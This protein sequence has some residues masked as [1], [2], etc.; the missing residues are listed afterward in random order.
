MNAIRTIENIPS[1]TNLRGF[2]DL[3]KFGESAKPYRRYGKS[4]ISFATPGK[5]GELNKTI[6]MVIL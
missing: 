4:T 1:V 6:S 3:E 2:L 5:Q